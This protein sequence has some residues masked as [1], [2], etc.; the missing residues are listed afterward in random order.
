MKFL[1]FATMAPLISALMFESGACIPKENDCS[2]YKTCMENKLKCGKKGY[3]LGYG[4]KYCKAFLKRRPKF[5]A[6]G[7]EWLSKVTLCNQHEIA[8]VFIRSS[9]L[10]CARVEEHAFKIHSKCYN[11]S[12]ISVCS[13]PRSDWRKILWVMKM[14]LAD[15]DTLKSAFKLALHCGEE[16]INDFIDAMTEKFI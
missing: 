15:R 12:N 2:F 4:G 10:T 13:L 9:N 8:S 6:L 16:F 1:T 5:S 11:A 14:E 3:A 7:Q